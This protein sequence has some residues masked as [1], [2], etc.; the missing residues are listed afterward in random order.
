MCGLFDETVNPSIICRGR[1]DQLT[2]TAKGS[3]NPYENMSPDQPF[4]FC[5]VMP[6]TSASQPPR[7]LSVNSAE[8]CE[9]ADSLPRR[10]ARIYEGDIPRYGR[11]GS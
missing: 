2:R 9:G 3:N 8:E 4:V 7:P 10:L 5:C 1:L 11:N 6:F